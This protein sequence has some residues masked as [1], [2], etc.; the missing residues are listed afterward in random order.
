M[1]AGPREYVG[2]HAV[3]EL[4]PQGV[5][6]R[7]ESAQNGSHGVLHVLA[8]CLRWLDVHVHASVLTDRATVQQ[9]LEREQDGGLASLPGRM[10]HEVPLVPHELQNLGEIHPF[11]RRDAVVVRGD[12]GTFG[13]ESAHGSKYGTH[14]FD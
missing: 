2:P 9:I 13:V 7:G 14:A 8:C 10:Q 12:D 5:R 11:E 4:V 1:G 6:P 3:Q